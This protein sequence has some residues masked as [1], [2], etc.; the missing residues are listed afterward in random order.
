MD[1]DELLQVRSLPIGQAE[2]Y[3]GDL[4]RASAMALDGYALG[5]SFIN[6][7]PDNHNF[8]QTGERTTSCVRVQYTY[9]RWNSWFLLEGRE[10]P[11]SVCPPQD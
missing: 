9:L 1:C 7:I 10:F 8:L 6:F 4:F 3:Y 5:L 11:F 2:T